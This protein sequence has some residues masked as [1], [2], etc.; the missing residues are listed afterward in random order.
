MKAIPLTPSHQQVRQFVLR[1]AQVHGIERKDIVQALG[2]KSP[3]LSN[4]CADNDQ[5]KISMEQIPAF[6]KAVKMSESET[7]YL[8][9][10]RL[11]EQEGGQ[12]TIDMNL[13]SSAFGH[14]LAPSPS[15]QQVLQTYREHTASLPFDPLKEP[16]AQ[17]H[18][19]RAFSSL[20]DLT[21]ER[22]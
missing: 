9:M 14:Y 16:S 22:H 13:L 15:E 21:I 19:N 7:A 10:T 18:L 2:I 12:I 6:A 1:A 20:V 4:W 17:A 3:A 8:V 11:F 5:T